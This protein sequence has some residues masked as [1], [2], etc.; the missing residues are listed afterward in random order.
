[1]VQLV[2]SMARYPHVVI[3]CAFIGSLVYSMALVSTFIHLWESGVFYGSGIHIYTF[4]E[5]LMA[6]LSTSMH[7]L[8]G[9]CI[10]YTF[11]GILMAPAST[12]M[13][14]SWGWCIIWLWYL[15]LCSIYIYAFIERLGYYT[16]LASILWDL[17]ILYLL[18]HLDT[19]HEATVV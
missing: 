15:H 19:Y 11:I 17:R 10:I 5:R 7:F 13:H 16:A 3:Y 18:G 2:Y 1:M 6:L 8:R 12:F 9:W 4:I 14:L